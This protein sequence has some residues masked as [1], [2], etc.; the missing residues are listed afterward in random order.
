[1]EDGSERERVLLGVPLQVQSLFCQVVKKRRPETANYVERHLAANE[2]RD[3][4]REECREQCGEDDISLFLQSLAP[5][6][7]RLAPIKAVFCKNAFIRFL[8]ETE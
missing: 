8:H 3:R 5:V 2:A 6:I 4:V 1:M 7:R